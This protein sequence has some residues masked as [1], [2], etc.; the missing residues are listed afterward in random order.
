MLTL[1]PLFQDHAV[2][3][4]KMPIPVWGKAEPG[5]RLKADLS[6]TTAF[7]RVAASGSFKL[8][9]PPMTAGGPFIFTISDLESGEQITFQDVMVGEVWL[10]SGQS[11]MEYPLSGKGFSRPSAGDE[12]PLSEIQMQEY[13]STIPEGGKF[14]FITIP[15][16]ASGCPEETF[17]GNWRVVTPE[18]AGDLSAAAAWFGKYIQEK[19][20][21]PVGVIHCSWGGSRAIGWIGRAGLFSEPETVHFVNQRDAEL[22][23][24]DLWDERKAS[25]QPIPIPRE[26]IDPGNRGVGWGWAATDFNDSGWVDF[27]VPGSWVHQKYSGNGAVWIRKT[28]ELPAHWTGKNLSLE[29]G[30]V[31]KM[32]ISYF[33][34]TEIGRSG[35]EL[36]PSFWNKRRS[37]PIPANLVKPGKNTVA[38]RAYSYIDDGTFSGTGDLYY[39]LEP[40]S[41]E[42]IELGGSWKFQ[43]EYNMGITK[44]PAQRLG[45]CNIYTPSILF[46]G[47][48][49]PIKT[50]GI[51]GVIWYQ[52]ESDTGTLAEALAYRKK[53]AAMIRDWRYAW[54]QGDFPFIQMQ[55]AGYNLG[56]QS[57][58]DPESWWSVLS[59][60]QRRICEDLPGVYMASAVDIGEAKDIHPQNKKTAGYRLA[61]CALNNVYRIREKAP[62]GPRFAGCVQEGNSIRVRFR[63]ADGLTLK[64][65]LPRSFYIAGDDHHFYPADKV[66]IEGDTLLLSSEKVEIPCAVRYAWSGFPSNTLYNGDGLPASPFRSDDWEIN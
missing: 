57:E 58:Y 15:R 6:G 2:F 46:E 49:N 13:I 32:D 8:R 61:L 33:N 39:L 1:N 28:V 48:I 18:S 40:E 63:Y 5:H 55:L 12:T 62:E 7:T 3:Q 34:G 41:G 51:R 60:N 45:P 44:R 53:L 59:D 56:S 9:L 30:P 16:V 38:I 47:M 14:R 4:Q 66:R 50:Y 43:S 31:D 11:N 17:T 22:A 20:D 19:L 42:R 65:D 29:L 21:V 24:A 52:G 36:D 27:T 54:E 37:Y 26:F 64:E 25:Q 23:K 35:K 10:A